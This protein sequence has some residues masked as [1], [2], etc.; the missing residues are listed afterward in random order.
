[1]LRYLNV[2]GLEANFI[3]IF[4]GA[5]SNIQI[6]LSLAFLG[7]HASLYLLCFEEKYLRQEVVLHYG[8]SQCVLYMFYLLLECV[9]V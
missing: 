3:L 4:W 2:N 9:T 1:M 8:S 5:T 6:L 7:S